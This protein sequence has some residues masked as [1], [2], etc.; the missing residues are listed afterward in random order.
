MRD[1]QDAKST[2]TN[3]GYLVGRLNINERFSKRDLNGWIQSFVP[4]NR[5]ERVLDVCCG[6]GKQLLM[7]LGAVGPT[8]EVHGFDASAEALEHI[9]KSLP[10][11]TTNAVL[12]QG[13]MEDMAQLLFDWSGQFDWVTCTYGL[14]YSKDTETTL[15]VLKSLL[16]PRGRLAIVGPARLNNKNFY[17]VVG[18]VSRIPD[19]VI[20]SSTVF[21]DETVM[22]ICRALFKSIEMYE[23]QN[24][25]VYPDI[26]SVVSYWRSC[27]TYYDEGALGNFKKQLE[28]HF[29]ENEDFRVTKEALGIVC[30]D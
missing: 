6:T 1:S 11:N 5:G 25:I 7:Y 30:R 14:Y 23:F 26:E 15:S 28:E 2:T 3:A 22:P 18:S 8:G 21:M 4:I 27:G 20:Y 12:H 16:K 13:L 29:A 10:A 24:E 19:F 17:E 9:R